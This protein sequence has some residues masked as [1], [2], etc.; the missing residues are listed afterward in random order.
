VEVF[1]PVRAQRATFR[2][3]YLKL[4]KSGELSRRVELG[5]EKL[6]DCAL[7]PRNCLV[8]RLQDKTRVCKT[9]RYA[10]VS[11]H[12]AHFGEERCLR[13]RRGSGTI[14]L[15]WCNLRCVFCQNYQISWLGEGR[16]S[17]PDEQAEVM[18]DLRSMLSRRFWSPPYRRWSAA[19]AFLWFRTRAPTTLRIRL[20]S[21]TGS[22]TYM[23]DFKFWD[24]GQARRYAKAPDYPDTARRAIKEMHRQVG[25]L[26][27]D[28]HGIALRGVLLR[29]LVMPGGVA[30]THEIMQWIACG[31]GA[32]TYVNLMAQYH[33][34]CRLSEA[35]YPE[36]NRCITK[37]DLQRA[38]NS[39]YAAGLVR[40]DSDAIPVE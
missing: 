33:P 4:W 9:G 25:P 5:L 37:S 26:V 39:F 13:G 21:W 28:E 11:S 40:L 23:P 24:P 31:L 27:T 19:S 32:D 35:E 6:A 22:L 14:F 1:S 36:I 12:F 10:V 7:C 17:K 15:S 16:A 2:P 30:G 8:N 29:H 38:L 18:L 3:A 20:H 34:A